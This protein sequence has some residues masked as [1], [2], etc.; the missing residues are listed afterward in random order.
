[1]GRQRRTRREHLTTHAI[2]PVDGRLR[3]VTLSM[4]RVR[5]AAMRSEGQLRE[6]ALVVPMVLQRPTAIFQGLRREE[7]EP[8]EGYGWRCYCG[9]PDAAY[10]QDGAARQPWPGEV[11]LV[12]VTEDWIVYNWYWT[13][14]A[15]DSSDLPAGYEERFRERVL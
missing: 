12:F 13:K 11:F 5:A 2:D 10:R 14:C 1:M 8:H 15:P 6:C 7:D 4:A 9:I 3:E